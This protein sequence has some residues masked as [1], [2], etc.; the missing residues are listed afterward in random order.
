MTEGSSH[1]HQRHRGVKC[2]QSDH[3]G[4][5]STWGGPR[6]NVRGHEETA[7][8]HVHLLKRRA[9][10][11]EA[12]DVPGVPR[13]TER[14]PARPQGKGPMEG[15]AGSPREPQSTPAREPGSPSTRGL[16]PLRRGKATRVGTEARYVATQLRLSDVL[17]GSAQLGTNAKRT[18]K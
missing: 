12:E 8:D 4:R 16:V 18:Q 10:V 13:G 5:W 17:P 9:R 1:L 15:H 2:D 14:P 7:P 11:C 3:M 6:Q